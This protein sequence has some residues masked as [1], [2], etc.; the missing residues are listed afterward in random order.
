MTTPG[1]I[2]LGAD[3]DPNDAA[4]P[5]SAA[6]TNYEYNVRGSV[7]TDHILWIPASKIHEMVK[8]KK[9][10]CGPVSGDYSLYDMFN[11]IVATD[12][13]TDTS[14]LGKLSL[15]AEILPLDRQYDVTAKVPRN[16]VAL[17]LSSDQAFT[18]SVAS[19]LNFDESV[20]AGFTVSNASGVYTLPC[21]TYLIIAEVSF[22]DTSIEAFSTFVEIKKD[23][24][25]LSPPVGS[26]S[27]M[28]SAAASINLENSLTCVVSSAT[29][30]TIEVECTLGG[31]AGTLTARGDNCRLTFLAM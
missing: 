3:F 21:G 26:S 13:C 22:K 20:L 10:R 5:S 7:N 4:P 25:S 6:L 31:T 8:T 11:L 1:I 27:A 30:F 24:A 2:Y 9:V 18:D 12:D 23:G 29:S 14:D 19:A 28:Q 16:V 15:I 17:N